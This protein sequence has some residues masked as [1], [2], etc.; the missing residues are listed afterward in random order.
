MLTGNPGTGT[1]LVSEAGQRAGAWTPKESC[2][3]SFAGKAHE[4]VEVGYASAESRACG[5]LGITAEGEDAIEH[6]GS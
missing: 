3:Q 5:T 6:G 1:A 4:L 2:R